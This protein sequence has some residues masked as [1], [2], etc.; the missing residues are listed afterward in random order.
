MDLHHTVVNTYILDFAHR[1][2][3]VLCNSEHTNDGRPIW[4]HV[5]A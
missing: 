2:I 3:H 4:K 5:D 1:S